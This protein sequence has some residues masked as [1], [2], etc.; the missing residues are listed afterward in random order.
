[1]FNA[2]Y[3]ELV[4]NPTDDVVGFELTMQDTQHDTYM[5]AAK[6]GRCVLLEFRECGQSNAVAAVWG[7]PYIGV[8]VS[9]SYALQSRIKKLQNNEQ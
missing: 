8:G 9:L 4:H 3:K 5:M 6:R 7:S 1:M 2:T